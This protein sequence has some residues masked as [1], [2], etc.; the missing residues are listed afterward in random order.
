MLSS[1]EMTC[2][3]KVLPELIQRLSLESFQEEKLASCENK[4]VSKIKTIGKSQRHAMKMEVKYIL[5]DIAEMEVNNIF[6]V[7]RNTCRIN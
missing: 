6:K 4:G 3:V 7:N 1:G 2:L 5:G